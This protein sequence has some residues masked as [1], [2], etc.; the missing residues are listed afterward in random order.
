MPKPMRS[1]PGASNEIQPRKAGRSYVVG[2]LGD[3]GDAL[4]RQ[5]E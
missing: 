2:V 1:L 3:P 5:K 4:D